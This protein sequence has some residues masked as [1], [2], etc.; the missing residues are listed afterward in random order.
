[1]G[2]LA[3]LMAVLKM[4]WQRRSAGMADQEETLLYSH[5]PGTPS[6]KAAAATG[7]AAAASE[8]DAAAGPVVKKFSNL[9]A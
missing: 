2:L 6:K 3:G 1:M 5:I 8:A 7:S 4:V 9:P